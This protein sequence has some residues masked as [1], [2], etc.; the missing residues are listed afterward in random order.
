MEE[1]KDIRK[2]SV[3]IVF[4]AILVGACVPMGP[5]E[6]EI[7]TEVARQ[8]KVQLT[9]IAASGTPT[10]T[11][12]VTEPAPSVP[13]PMLEWYEVGHWEGNG[14]FVS[15]AFEVQSSSWRV[16]WNAVYRG[17]EWYSGWFY[18][19]VYEP[20]AAY[21]SARPASVDLD[22]EEG[23]SEASNVSYVHL[24]PGRYYLEIGDK[25]IEWSVT[26]EDQR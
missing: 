12:V 10:D 18:I 20:G 26:V 6:G 15:P 4:C 23:V 17:P 16:H 11:P 24:G 21:D 9:A 19:W 22:P 13:T 25:M 2:G 3:F 14:A 5:S 7:A 1:G 8:V